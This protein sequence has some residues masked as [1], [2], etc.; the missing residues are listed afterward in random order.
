MADEFALV[1]DFSTL[2]DTSVHVT[3]KN[4]GQSPALGVKI[5]TQSTMTGANCPRLQAF[6]AHDSRTGRSAAIS[7]H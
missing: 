6:A 2:S 3:F 4:V 7:V 1:Q 5:H